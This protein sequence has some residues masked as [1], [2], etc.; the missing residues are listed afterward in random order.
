M[1]TTFRAKPVSRLRAEI[2]CI[3]P[4][5]LLILF[6]L[7]RPPMLGLASNGD[8]ERLMKWGGLAYAAEAYD[9]K[10]F[11][12]VNR[13]FRFETDPWRGRVGFPSSEVLF[14]KPAAILGYCLLDREHFDLRLLGLLH[15]LGYA[16]AIRLLLRGWAM[17]TG[18][19]CLWLLPGLLLVFC[20]LGYTAYFNSFYSE[21]ATLIFLLAMTGAGL[22]LAVRNGFF[23]VLLFCLTAGLFVAAKPQLFPMIPLL[24]L[25]SAVLVIR[26]RSRN[27]R[28]M[29]T[30]F[31]LSLVMPAGA[32][33]I[34]ASWYARNG[35]YQSIFYGI[36]K[37]SPT[38]AQDLI[39]LG[40]DPK[41]AVMA[42]T[43]VFHSDLP[44][45]IASEE[46]RR[47]F[48]DR[49]TH[50]TILRYYLGH[51]ARFLAKLDVSSRNAYSLR[52]PYAGNYEKASGR[53]AQAKAS[54]WTLWSDFK[55]RCWPKSFPVLVAYC[56]GLLVLILTGYRQ[57][58][59]EG[60]RLREFLLLL[61][62]MLPIAFVTP[63]LG[64]GESDLTRHLFL[65]N[66]LFDLSLLL[67]SAW[68]MM[69]VWRSLK[70]VFTCT[71]PQR[72]NFF[73]TRV[74]RIKGSRIQ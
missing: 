22:R 24:L 13:E 31:S 68:G 55:D 65:F 42:N 46:F 51:P 32:F 27:V 4:L 45:D 49:I 36:L 47:S 2:L 25:F 37:D 19:T 38:P 56:L 43:T 17:A 53:P 72:P 44:I 15:L 67:L 9:E 61:W 63:I 29:L 20:D 1:M 73:N 18:R 35:C 62:A 10:Y 23:D 40:L 34:L 16:A 30:V 39:D 74:Q 66:A 14:I 3:V 50:L 69:E 59:I 28:L 11:G 21:P 33:H 12:W 60:K 6:Q 41:F 52:L 5:T 48:Y 8:F 57:A 64:D 54:R 71:R 58:T 70:A 7:F 26:A